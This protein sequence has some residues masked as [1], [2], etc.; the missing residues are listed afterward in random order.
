MNYKNHQGPLPYLFR[1]MKNWQNTY[2]VNQPNIQDAAQDNMHHQARVRMIAPRDR[3][4]PYGG[5]TSSLPFEILTK[6]YAMASSKVSSRPWTP[7]R[8]HGGP[9]DGTAPKHLTN[10]IE[11]MGETPNYQHHRAPLFY[12]TAN[13][14]TYQ[15]AHLDPEPDLQNIG[16]KQCI[17]TTWRVQEKWT[18][19]TA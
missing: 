15:S 16:Q 10:I 19:K 7:T 14:M 18:P 2:I 6:A 4:P 11:C 3:T 9:M 8:D 13:E 12:P 1:N 5:Q 17:V